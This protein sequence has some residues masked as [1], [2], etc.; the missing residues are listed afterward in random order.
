M[1]IPATRF[2][3][4]DG[5]VISGMPPRCG[6]TG[7]DYARNGASSFG[8]HFGKTRPHRAAHQGPS[9]LWKKRGFLRACSPRPP[10]TLVELSVDATFLGLSVESA[11]MDWPCASFRACCCS[12]HLRFQKAR[13]GS[14]GAFGVMWCRNAKSLKI[15]RTIPTLHNSI[16]GF[17]AAGL[18]SQPWC[19]IKSRHETTASARDRPFIRC[20]PCRFYGMD[21]CGPEELRENLAR[22]A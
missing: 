16:R 6:N 4:M 11:K 3:Q 2:A 10:I 13:T 21:A 7:H 8:V 19:V 15:Y 5:L 1:E 17:R 22:Q 18:H 20:R 9:P 14:F 12:R